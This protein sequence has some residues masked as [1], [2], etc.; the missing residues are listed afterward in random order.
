[1]FSCEHETGATESSGA[2]GLD[3][4]AIRLV[5]TELQRRVPGDL[6]L[7]GRSVGRVWMGQVREGSK[8]VPN[9]RSS[10]AELLYCGHAKSSPDK[11][12]MTSPGQ[13][14][15][16]LFLRE[17]PLCSSSAQTLKLKEQHNLRCSCP[18]RGAGIERLSFIQAKVP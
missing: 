16:P 11:M 3:R 8:N 18:Q 9:G 14:K 1:M 5:Q 7:A 6:C 15:A 13:T 2:G 17:L 10:V 4:A 12:S